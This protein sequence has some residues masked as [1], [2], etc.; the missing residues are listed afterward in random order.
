M[1]EITFIVAFGAGLASFLSPCVL[2][3]VPVYLASLCGPEIFEA[4]ARRRRLPIF[5]HALSFATGFLAVFVILGVSAGLT[6]FVIGAHLG[7]IRQISGILLIVFGAFMLAALR[8][9][10]LSYEKRLALPT[11]HSIGYL[12][13]FLTGSVFTLAWTPCISPILGGILTL[14]WSS[15]TVSQGAVLLA[16]Y[17]LGL[18][19]PFLAIGAAIDSLLPL[20]KRIGRYSGWI[21]LASGLLLIMVGI[22]ILTNKLSWLQ[23]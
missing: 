7:V 4:G 20:I 3:V 8:V 1:S 12:R 14:A 18:A 6:G 21:Y 11:G 17:A 2:P 10:W 16:V 22:L 23:V 13:S 9:P 19:L 15:A 5:L